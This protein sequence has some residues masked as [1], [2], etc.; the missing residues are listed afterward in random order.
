MGVSGSGAGAGS[1]SREPG[2]VARFLRGGVVAR[3]SDL[4]CGSFFLICRV[5][6]RG[7]IC[8]VIWYQW[9]IWRRVGDLAAWRRLAAVG[10]LA[11]R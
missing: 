3:G 10:D 11:A 9:E 6:C 5:V 7:V 4:F 2:D 8:R 1:G